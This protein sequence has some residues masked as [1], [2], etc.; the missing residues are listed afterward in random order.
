MHEH[1]YQIQIIQIKTTKQD[2]IPASGFATVSN[3]QKGLKLL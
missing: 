3:H 1:P 2:R